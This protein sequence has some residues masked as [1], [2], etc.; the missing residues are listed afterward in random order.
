M[1]GAAYQKPGRLGREAAL[2]PG[3]SALAVGAD[4][5]T[6]MAGRKWLTAHEATALFADRRLVRFRFLIVTSGRHSFPPGCHFHFDLNDISEKPS[7]AAPV[8]IR[9]A[10]PPF[11]KCHRVRLVSYSKGLNFART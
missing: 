3:G 1:A 2:A 5:F 8:F 11:S 7:P 9:T 10:A 4:A 6:D